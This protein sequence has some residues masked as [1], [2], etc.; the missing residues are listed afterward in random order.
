[1]IN[2]VE[3]LNDLRRN[4]RAYKYTK[5]EINLAIDTAISAVKLAD[6]LV[7]KVTSDYLEDLQNEYDLG[8][9]CGYGDRMAEEE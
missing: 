1:M 6:Y 7:A 5:E 3:I 4:E 2:V 9:Q 8:Y